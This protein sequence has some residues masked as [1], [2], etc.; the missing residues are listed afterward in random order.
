[1][2]MICDMC[3]YQ[4]SIWKKVFPIKKDY[5]LWWIW[6]SKRREDVAKWYDDDVRGV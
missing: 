1:M 5:V 2:L 6:V 4:Y 3:E